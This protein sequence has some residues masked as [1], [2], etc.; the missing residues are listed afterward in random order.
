MIFNSYKIICFDFD[1][2]IVESSYLKTSAYRTLFEK[3]CPS[4]IDEIMD[5]HLKNSGIIRYKKIKDICEK[6]INIE[7]T[8]EL[9]EKMITEYESDIFKKVCE[10]PEVP[11]A[12]KLLGSLKKKKKKFI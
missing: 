11:G 4:K 5:Y 9:E 7:F 12:E 8:P 1:G 2:V 10:C 3:Y 6:I